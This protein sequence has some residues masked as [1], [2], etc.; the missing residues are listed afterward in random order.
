MEEKTLKNYHRWLNSNAVDEKDKEILRKMSESEIDDAFFQ[1]IKFGTA[2]ISVVMKTS[3]TMVIPHSRFSPRLAICS[4]S[5][6]TTSCIRL[7]RFPTSSLNSSTS[8]E[9]TGGRF[10]CLLFASG[11]EIRTAFS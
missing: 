5:S 4:S 9:S 8:K 6:L 2:G 3:A 1:D 7:P 10:S 11:T